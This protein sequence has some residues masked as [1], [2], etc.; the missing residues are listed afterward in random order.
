MSE[1]LIA[2][3]CP[4]T[5]PGTQLSGTSCSDLNGE[6]RH[7]QLRRKRTAYEEARTLQAGPERCSHAT[8]G[9]NRGQV[10]GQSVQ[11]VIETGWLL[12]DAGDL[13]AAAGWSRRAAEWEDWGGGTPTAGRIR[14]PTRQHAVTAPS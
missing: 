1:S 9:R 5:S 2:T 3:A 10:S 8:P 7:S 4:R 11:G 14:L 12:Q 6:R 13:D